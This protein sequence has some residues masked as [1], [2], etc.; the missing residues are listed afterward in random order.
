[1]PIG[2]GGDFYEHDLAHIAKVAMVPDMAKKHPGKR[3]CF[4]HFKTKVIGEY[5]IRHPV[6]VVEDRPG[7]D[8]TT[9]DIG[10]SEA[11]A[12]DV[13]RMANEALGHTDADVDDIINSSIRAES[14]SRGKRSRRRRR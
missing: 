14:M 4:D 8:P 6:V 9:F 1:M 10:H 7:F 11:T 2:K 13:V 3:F 12:L 5:G